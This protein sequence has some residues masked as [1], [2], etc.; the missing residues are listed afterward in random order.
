MF[1]ARACFRA[2]RLGDRWTAASTKATFSGV[3]TAFGLP[4]PQGLLVEPV[5]CNA[6]A[7]RLI[8]LPSG[9]EP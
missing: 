9:M 3:L 4:L 2:E 7:Q 5:C 1:N 8:V 6:L